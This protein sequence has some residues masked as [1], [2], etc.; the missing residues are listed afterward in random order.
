MNVEQTLEKSYLWPI[1]ELVA[2]FPV[3]TLV[4]KAIQND[5][6]KHNKSLA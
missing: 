1:F 2:Y 4:I 5:F 3:H 6:K